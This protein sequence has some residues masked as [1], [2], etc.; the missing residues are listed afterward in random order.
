LFDVPPA[1]PPPPKPI[2]RWCGFH[3][4]PDIGI[5]DPEH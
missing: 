1:A 2:R 5:D 4:R 3:M